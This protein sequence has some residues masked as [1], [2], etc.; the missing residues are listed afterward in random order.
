MKILLIN[1]SWGNRFQGQRFNR[2]WPPLDLL[3]TA[4]RLR[5]SGFEVELIDARAAGLRPD[6]AHLPS[7]DLVVVSTSPLDRWQCPNIDLEPLLEWTRLIEPEKLIIY[8]IHGTLFPES[9]LDLTGAGAVVRG[10]P[11]DTVPALCLAMARPG[12]SLEALP[13]ISYRDGARIVHNPPAPPV[14]LSTLPLPAYDLADPRGYRYELLGGRMALLETA[15]G[16]PHSCT[17]CLKTMYG[18]KVRKKPTARVA[19]EVDLVRSAGYR[20][21]YFI[22]LEFCLDRRRALELCA[23]MRDAGLDW[24]CQTRVDDVDP[25][26]LRE[27]AASGCRLIHYGVESG[28]PGTPIRTEKRISFSQTEKAIHWAK[29]A[30]IGTAAFFLLGFSWETPRDWLET[31]R[32][33]RKLNPTYASFHRVTPYAGTR[34]G[35][36]ARSTRPWWEM[37]PE[38]SIPD[39]RLRRIYLRYYLRSAYIV[40]LLRNGTNLLSAAGLFLDFLRGAGAAVPKKKPSLNVM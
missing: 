37:A 12:S 9:L 39:S 17:F 21:V 3:Y 22:D 25:E 23:V 2:S 30:G 13:S 1:P 38:L 28:A 40:E 16:C 29:S 19:E 14:D 27:M 24:C 10:E 6:A 26:L 34:L 4:A 36:A 15:R 35:G 18:D 33:A 20:H 31:E 11:E 7:T 5:A 8:G 32:F